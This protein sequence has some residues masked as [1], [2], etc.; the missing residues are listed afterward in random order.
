[1]KLTVT[2]D[3]LK[4]E[5]ASTN[6]LNVEEVNEQDWAYV[7]DTLGLTKEDDSIRLVLKCS[8]NGEPS[9]LI[10]EGRKDK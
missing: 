5:L 10:T 1:M 6:Q 3:S 7:F 4:I 8:P 9:Y 2:K